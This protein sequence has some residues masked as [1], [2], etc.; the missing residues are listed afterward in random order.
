MIHTEHIINTKEEGSF[1]IFK[2]LN[3][4]ILSTPIRVPVLFYGI[5][6]CIENSLTL[7]TKIITYIIMLY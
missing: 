7:H 1:N 2:I 6:V 5:L 3:K 4:F